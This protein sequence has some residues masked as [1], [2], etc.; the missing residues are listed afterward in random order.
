MASAQGKGGVLV[1][2]ASGKK[3]ETSAAGARIERGGRVKTDA[4]TRA[5]LKLSDGSVVTL[6]R[7]TE[8]ALLDGDARGARLTSGALV[9]DV[10]HQKSQARFELPAGGVTVHGTKFALRAQGR[11]ASVDVTRGSVTLSDAEKR[12]V[13]VSEGESGRLEPGAEPY[14][15]YSSALADSLGWSDEAFGEERGAVAGRGLGELKARKPGQ[16]EERANAVVLS[17]HDVRVRI[18]GVVARTEI[19]EVFE[20]HT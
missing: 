13:R 2:D 7:S 14:V 11:S 12:S 15:A 18:S 6:D 5:E 20:N 16:T 17:S 8:L 3:C 9:A 19:E 4:A 10:A 1:C